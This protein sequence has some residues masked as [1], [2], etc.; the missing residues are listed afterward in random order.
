[1]FRWEASAKFEIFEKIFCLVFLKKCFTLSGRQQRIA[2]KQFVLAQVV[3]ST[4]VFVYLHFKERLFYYRRNNWLTSLYRKYIY[5]QMVP[6]KYATSQ[7]KLNNFNAQYEFM[8]CRV[9]DSVT[10]CATILPYIPWVY[11][12]H[13]KFVNR[14]IGD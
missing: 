13:Y 5:K 3:T 6:A 14:I 1:M 7:L 10:F 4:N 2:L 8:G 12:L 11:Q 9:P